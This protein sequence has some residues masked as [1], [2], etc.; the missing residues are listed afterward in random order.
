MPL[1]TITSTVTIVLWG[2]PLNLPQGSGSTTSFVR[3]SGSYHFHWSYHWYVHNG[4]S[5][6]ILKVAQN[7]QQADCKALISSTLTSNF[8]LKNLKDINIALDSEPPCK[9]P[10]R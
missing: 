6:T 7:R 8:C 2:I 3:T 4:G 5:G 9:I 10:L 1:V